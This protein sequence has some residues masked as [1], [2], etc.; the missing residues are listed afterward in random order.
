MKTILATILA[1]TILLSACSVHPAQDTTCRGKY[2]EYKAGECCLDANSNNIC[3]T[4]E[5]PTQEEVTASEPTITAEDIDCTALMGEEA[6]LYPV[7]GQDGSHLQT[8]AELRAMIQAEADAETA[9]AYAELTDAQ[10]AEIGGFYKLSDGLY[11]CAIATSF[12]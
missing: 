4:D 12:R 5:T 7:E 9:A 8:Y 2:L 1:I 6:F 3:D 11:N 10:L